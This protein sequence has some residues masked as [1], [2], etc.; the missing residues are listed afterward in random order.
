MKKTK[1]PRRVRAFGLWL[2]P[3]LTGIVAASFI[4]LFT[5]CG[6]STLA[7]QSKKVDVSERN[8]VGDGKTLNTVAIQAVIDQCANQ[9]GGTVVIPQGEFL[10]GALFLKPGVNLDLL[11][12]AVLKGSTNINDYPKVNTRI[13]GHFQP[14]RAALL[15]GDQ[16]DHLRITGPGMLDGS[17]APFWHEFYQRFR[18]DRKTTNLDV[19]R[20]RLAFIQNSA[21]VQVSGV[22]FTNSGFW[23]LHL[24]R[25]RNATVT[26]CRFIALGP[27]PSTDGIDVDSSQ[28]ITISHCFFQVGDDD[29]A[30]KGS[31]GPFAMQDKDSPP[32]ERI[33]ILDSIFVTGGGI[34]TAGS[35]ATIVRDVDVERCTTRGPT[36]LRLKLRPDTAQ[37]YENIHLHDI[38]MEGAGVIFN[39]SPWRQYF[40]LQGQPPPKSLVRNITISD[41]HGSGGSFGKI[42]GNP[43]TDISDIAVKNVDVKLKD[44]KF[45]AGAV[46][47]LKFD[48]VLVN[49]SPFAA[50]VPAEP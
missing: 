6:C 37:Q 48:N 13:E 38:T 28:D 25:C 23:N 35:E 4:V 42:I 14:W 16:V 22:T 50:P 15:N 40:D 20:P 47:S 46:K 7:P 11:A 10:S 44:T 33:H 36:V 31:K 5:F 8:A 39:V 49:G 1:H 29:I 41:V 21:D 3:R 19:E 30:L 45:D 17:G 32:V 24:Y 26:G 18:A 12:G 9:G 43:N 27:A 34:A 2:K